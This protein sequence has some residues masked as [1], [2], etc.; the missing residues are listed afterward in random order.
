MHVI[1]NIFFKGQIL[2]LYLFLKKKA[3]LLYFTCITVF[4]C[5]CVWEPYA[6]LMPVEARRGNQVPWN[7]SYKW[8]EPP[9]MQMLGTKVRSFAKATNMFPKSPVISLAHRPVSLWHRYLL[10]YRLISSSC[11]S[12]VHTIFLLLVWVPYLKSTLSVTLFLKR[13]QLY[14]HLQCFT[15]EAILTM[16]SHKYPGGRNIPHQLQLTQEG[17]L[18]SAKPSR[19]SV[20]EI[21]SCGYCL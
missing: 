20:L 17:S 1:K 10:L 16:T 5:T 8:C 19:V 2:N 13:S 18:M 21:C 15:R 11:R 3:N 4:G 9:T 12:F 14:L 7:W 6:Y